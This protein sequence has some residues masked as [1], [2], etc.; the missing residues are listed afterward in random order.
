MMNIIHL[1]CVW[2]GAI[3]TAAGVITGISVQKREIADAATKAAAK[4]VT[5]ALGDAAV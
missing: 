1:V 5:R 3:L 2:G 4:A